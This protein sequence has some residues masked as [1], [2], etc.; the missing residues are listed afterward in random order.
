VFY[1]LPAR[2][3]ELGV[4]VALAVAELSWKRKVVS[5]RWLQVVSLAGLALILIPM[6]L[7]TSATP[8]PGPTALPSVLGTALVIATRGSWINRIPLSLS[9]LV[10]IGRISYSWYLWHW[11]V[12]A[13]LRI[14]SGGALPAIAIAI[15][16][17]ASFGAAVLS[18]Y[19]IEQPFRGSSLAPAPLLLRY[20]A[21]SLFFLGMCGILWVSRGLPNRYPA[22]IEDGVIASDLCLADY[23]VDRPDL[24]SLCYSR[25]DPRPSIVLWG[26]SHS[27]A[28]APALR[29]AAN[30]QGYNFIQIGK[31]SCLPLIGVA[32]FVPQHPLV[33]KECI[34]FNHEVLNIIATDHRIRTVILAGR[35][36]D[37]FREGG[38]F[39][40]ISSL[41]ERKHL[42][43]S[44]NVRSTF[45]RSL[46]STIQALQQVG[47]NVIVV[48]D[49]PNFDFDPLWRFRT[50]R[51]AARNT[52]ALWL[53]L[54][55]SDPGSA[56]PASFLASRTSS[57]LL[58]E[59]LEGR[60]GVELIDPKPRFC[61]S[62]G[63]C[64]YRNGDRLLYLDEQHLTPSGAKFALQD[65][66]LPSL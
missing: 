2:A 65:F 42:P 23:G 55:T 1:L 11:P 56:S 39:S 60:P 29:Q 51:I 61:N 3:W 34:D 21:V 12:L 18:Y 66:S 37:P 19:L 32:K 47:K 41:Q 20:A 25:S 44:D 10:F 17:A 54:N 53:G 50:A 35:W 58:N 40:L 9:P 27:A 4:G 45:V 57:E 31:S 59:T 26:D 30:I 64:I 24:S 16:I 6:N 22:L 14:A 13:F 43:S 15:A 62:Q 33:V 63:L 28:L 8:F 5:A 38:A 52:I 48:D 49:V 7:L 36:G 46:S